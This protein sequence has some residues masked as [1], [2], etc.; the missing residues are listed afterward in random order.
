M[1]AGAG[2][3]AKRCSGMQVAAHPALSVGPLAVKEYGVCA[4]RWPSGTMPFS[5]AHQHAHTPTQVRR[6]A[7]ALQLQQLL[8]HICR[9]HCTH[10][11]MHA[12][13]RQAKASQQHMHTCCTARRRT[14]AMR[15]EI[16]SR[17]R[18]HIREQYKLH[19]PRIKAINGH[20]QVHCRQARSNWAAVAATAAA[21]M[22][23]GYAVLYACHT[24]T[25][26]AATRTASPASSK[27]AP[28]QALCLQPPHAGAPR[29]SDALARKRVMRDVSA[30]IDAAN[31]A[32]SY[33]IPL[34]HGTSAAQAAA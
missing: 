2:A 29:G 4:P 33:R 30:A 3:A 17:Q 26:K 7:L 23:R 18:G 25:T 11:G 15:P 12:P 22:A 19:A 16:F 27:A 34:V 24:A 5:P 28:V 10:A 21:A 31:L 1:R 9:Q 6:N 20:I 14:C 13:Y 32:A 8:Y